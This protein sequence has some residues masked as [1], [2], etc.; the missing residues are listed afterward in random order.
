MK[1]LFSSH[2]QPKIFPIGK[3]ASVNN[4]YLFNMINNNN[5]LRSFSIINSIQSYNRRDKEKKREL[6][7]NKFKSNKPFR[8]N[9]DFNNKPSRNFPR[10]KEFVPTFLKEQEQLNKELSA[11]PFELKKTII[12]DITEI[13]AGNAHCVG[14]G[15]TLQTND[16]NKPG[17]VHPNAVEKKVIEQEKFNKL[18]KEWEQIE[19]IRNELKTKKLQEIQIEKGLSSLEEAEEELEREESKPN[20]VN[21]NIPRSLTG[22]TVMD[23]DE[24]ELFK[25]YKNHKGKSL[26]QFIDD[27]LS[28]IVCQRCHQ[29]RNY[30]VY[31]CVSV[32]QQSVKQVFDRIRELKNRVLII[33]IIDLFDPFG[34]IIPNFK[35]IIGDKHSVLIVANKV[36]YLLKGKSKYSRDGGNDLSENERIKIKNYK[37]LE[38]WVR[39]TLK[40]DF[41]LF[42]T[43]EER[44]QLVGVE[45]VSSTTGTGMR[46]LHEKMNK[47]RKGSDVYV[48]GC[49][50][51]G[52]ST[53]INQLFRQQQST[54][55]QRSIQIT[56]S[57]LPGTTLKTISF[58]IISEN[59]ERANLFD[60]PGVVNKHQKLFTEYLKY[61]DWKYIIPHPDKINPRFVRLR[62]GRCFYLAGLFRLD[63]IENKVEKEEWDR[64]VFSVYGS[65]QLSIHCTN[66]ERAEEVYEKH[67][68]EVPFIPPVDGKNSP[69]YGLNKKLK[70][71]V[72]GNTR[73][74]SVVDVCIGGIG[75]IA[76]TGVGEMTFE[77]HTNE[78][79]EVYV[80]QP[81]LMPYSTL[82]RKILKHEYIEHKDYHSL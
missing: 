41:N 11:T 32:D 20:N 9:R 54:R 16:I 72:T 80:R 33:Y 18:T 27:S 31:S 50:N 79:V 65:T 63:Y 66:I 35:D 28:E 61:E 15:A 49:A 19:E 4:H 24:F 43:L 1:K 2:F 75:W 25:K 68:G 30:G 69:I 39:R 8:N 29:L 62:P 36:D 55:S 64:C 45:I 6:K 60:T 73:G 77:V 46:E 82:D 22:Y 67:A 5:T 7:E 70:F 34:S 10:D 23:L 14:C 12:S 47:Y 78:K 74:E 40:K 13:T 38:E 3:T 44:E 51:V 56:T 71:K 53:F 48:V 42:T 76:I 81:C 21:P 52:K 37:R 17:Y 58:P 59:G 57:S 26:Q